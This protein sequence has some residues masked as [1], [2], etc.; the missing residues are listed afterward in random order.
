MFESKIEKK[1]AVQFP[2]FTGTRIMMMP[3]HLHD[4]EVSLPDSL[5]WWRKSLTEILSLHSTGE[6]IGYL[7]LD[8]AEVPAGET[9]RRPGLHVDGIGPHGTRGAWSPAKWASKNGGMLVAASHVGCRGWDQ[10][11]EG[12]A[13]SNGDCAHLTSLCRKEAEIIMEAGSVYWCN[14]LAVHEALP[15]PQITRRQFI[16]ISMPSDAPW[17][18]G[19]TENPLG[20]KPEGATH[21]ARKTFMAYRA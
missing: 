14:S 18:E 5:S 8:E 15:M 7:T 12:H 11:F 1:G 21:P 4:P 16:R 17:Y 20:I 13:G 3:F 10:H 19:Y 6:G 2:E 9:H